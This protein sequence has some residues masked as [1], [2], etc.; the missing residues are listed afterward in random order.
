MSKIDLKIIIALSRANQ[1]ILKKIEKSMNKNGLTVSEFGVMELLLHK[2]KQPVQKIAERILV[3]SG[4]ITYVI[5]KL[6]KKGYIKRDEK[7]LDKRTN[8]IKLTA[9]GEE[10]LESSRN[11]IRNR[12]DEEGMEKYLDEL[13]VEVC[14]R[15]IKQIEEGKLELARY[16]VNTLYAWK[17]YEFSN[18]LWKKLYEKF[19]WYEG[20][21]KEPE[22]SEEEERRIAMVLAIEKG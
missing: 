8:L 4:T 12:I 18:A 16:Y 15:D 11:E 7:S 3:T 10:V 6:I 14:R 5:N 1:A 19:D 17:G 9:L 2:G 20:K 13:Y 22:L 21:T